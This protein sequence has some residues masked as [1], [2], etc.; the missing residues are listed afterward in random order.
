MISQREQGVEA[1]GAE[2]A[3]SGR[4]Q[5]RRQWSVGDDE[6]IGG[7]RRSFGALPRSGFVQR[8]FSLPLTAGWYVRSKSLLPSVKKLSQ[9][10]KGRL[11]NLVTGLFTT[12]VCVRDPLD[13]RAGLAQAAPATGSPHI[14]R[15]A[16][17]P[18]SAALRQFD[19]GLL[20]RRWSRRCAFCRDSSRR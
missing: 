7:Q 9:E 13:M 16:A 11:G 19:R 4:A 8:P 6:G 17:R 18:D 10:I 15:H 12:R 3:R 1:V 5:G 20:A 2:V 14:E